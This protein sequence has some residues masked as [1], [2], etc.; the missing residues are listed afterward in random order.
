MPA[1]HGQIQ[2]RKELVRL[3]GFRPR[4][5]EVAKV[6][7][8]Y[9]VKWVWWDVGG[10][11]DPRTVLV[12]RAKHLQNAVGDRLKFQIVNSGPFCYVNIWIPY[13]QTG[14]AKL[15]YDTLSKLR[16]HEPVLG[17]HPIA[18]TQ[19][20][21]RTRNKALFLD[22]LDSLDTTCHQNRFHKLTKKQKRLAL[23]QVA[24]Q[25]QKV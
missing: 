23:E 8:V 18:L 3:M 15:Y 10:S 22:L 20:K 5:Y 24:N 12:E 4:Y 2:I 21:T 13:I 1:I 14:S 19:A 9:R 16:E 7:K 17:L 25:Y 6:S 11:R